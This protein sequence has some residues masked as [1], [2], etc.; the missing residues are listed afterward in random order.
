MNVTREIGP[1]RIK[2]ELSANE[3]MVTN[4]FMI[5]WISIKKKLEI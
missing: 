3:A 5:H 1:E 4:I 2:S